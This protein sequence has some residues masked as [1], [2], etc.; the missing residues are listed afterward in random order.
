[1]NL[2]INFVGTFNKPNY[3]GEVSDETHI[4]RE[5]ERLGHTVN[6]I[7]RDVWKAYVDGEA[8]QG[9]WV[10]P[11]PSDINLIAKWHHFND[12]KYVDRL[13]AE[14]VAPVLYWVWDFMDNGG[15][16]DWHAQMAVAA[17]LYLS[18]E[19]GIFHKYKELGV[20]PYYFQMDV[21]DA[22]IQTFLPGNFYDVVFTGSY[23]K[24]GNRI[25]FLRE[26]TRQ[27]PVHIFAFNQEEWQND[28]FDNTHPAVFGEDYN[29]LI[30]DSKI[31]LGMS[32]EPN[33]WGYWSNRV[34]KVIAAGGFLLQEYAPGM[35]QFLPDCVEFFSTP[36]EA[37]EKIN[38]FLGN[39]IEVG[40]KKGVASRYKYNFTSAN[41]V[42]LLI[43][44]MERYLKGNPD[45]W[46][47]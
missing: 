2:N 14:S 27:I 41:K 23:E 33:C 4:A 16:P 17:D 8:I 39:P 18:G 25:E 7:E 40:L 31:V 28:G 10:L 6:R 43:K 38:H 12:R 35:E 45:L 24:Q 47:K 1:M 19:A 22:E 46:D 36:Q 44:L 26:I 5:F 29:R 13:R 32:V 9:D 34:G 20:S 21:C 3:I 11:K 42:G 15:I 30:A 37:I